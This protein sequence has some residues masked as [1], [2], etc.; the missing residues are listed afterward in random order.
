MNQIAKSK[1]ALLL[2]GLFA[3]M[4]MAAHAANIQLAANQPDAGTLLDTVRDKGY[5][6]PKKSEPGLEIQQQAEPAMHADNSTRFNVATF[7]FT[8]NTVFTESELQARIAGSAGHELTLADLEK[9]AGE[10]SQYYRSRGY[11]VARA[12]I[13]AQEIRDGVVQIAVLEGRVGKIDVRM[14]G[15]GK[16]AESSVAKTVEGAIKPGDVIRERK[17]EKGLLLANDLANVSVDSTLV[18]GASVGTSD[19][20]VEARRTGTFSGGLDYDNFGNKFTGESRVGASLNVG[21]RFGGTGSLRLM[22]SGTGLKYGRASYLEPVGNLGTKVGVAYSDMHYELGGAFAAANGYGRA[23]IGSLFVVHPVVRGRNCNLYAQL[24]YDGKHLLD[25]AGG[26]EK[27]DKHS[28]VYSLGVSGDSRDGFGSGGVNTYSLTYY[29]GSLDLDAQTLA[30]D[31]ASAQTSGSFDKT[32]Y[33]LSRIQ[34]L[35]DNF[36]LYASISGQAASKNLD[37]SEKFVLGGA[38]GVRAYP[39]GEATGDEGQIVNVELRRDLGANEYG[40]FQFIGFYDFGHI[41]L[42]KNTW[43]NWQGAGGNLS[44]NYNLSG[45]GLG[46]NFSRAGADSSGYSVKAFIAAKLGTNPNRGPNGQDSDGTSSSTRF[47]LQAS[48]WF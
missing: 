1:V 7:H 15:S 31:V 30:L 27:D 21:D 20:V 39:Q 41:Q 45:A 43:T 37:S 42:N 35:N 33:S 22:S 17:L 28:H 2:S 16:L 9:V 14:T 8:G 47:W 18:P 26:A 46:L 24:G 4:P 12:Y 5:A 38:G 34:R 6:P 25:N 36:A 10:I 29:N 23:D 44:N 40:N 19:L 13:P 48:K 11:F 3:A 32:A